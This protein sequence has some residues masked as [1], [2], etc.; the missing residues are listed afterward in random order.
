MTELVGDFTY[1]VASKKL[2]CASINGG[3]TVKIFMLKLI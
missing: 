2:M 1:L 3:I